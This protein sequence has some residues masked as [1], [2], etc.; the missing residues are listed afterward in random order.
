MNKSNQEQ[1]Q[2]CKNEIMSSRAAETQTDIPQRAL[3]PL[4]PPVPAAVTVTVTATVTVT[5]TVT[6]T[7]TVTVSVSVTAAVVRRR[8]SRSSHSS[9]CQLTPVSV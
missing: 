7:A 4:S 2:S 3:S 8:C 6:A 9:R 1:I 5:V